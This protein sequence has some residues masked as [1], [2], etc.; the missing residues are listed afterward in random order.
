[1]GD[2]LKEITADADATSKALTEAASS[3]ERLSRLGSQTTKEVGGITNAFGDLE[4]S[5]LRLTSALKGGVTA[6][7]SILSATPA[8]GPLFEGLGKNIGFSVDVLDTFIGV[9]SDALELAFNLFD[10]PSRDVRSFADG[11][12]DLNKRFGGTIEQAFVFA[13]V[14]KAETMSPFARALHLT[15]DEMIAFANA[16]GRTNITLEQQGKIVDTGIGRTNLLAATMALA[17]ASSLTVTEGAGLLN[18]ALNKQGKSAQDALEIMG[19]FT[20]VARETGLSID[21]VSS[22]LNSAVGNFT[23]LGISADFGVPLLQGFAR[24]MMDMGLGIENATDLTT[25]LSSALA[26][27]TTDYANAYI[28]FQRGG[29]EMG[30]SGGGGALG[31]SIGLQAEVLKADRTGDQSSL[32]TQLAKGMRDTLASFT[33]GNIVTVEQADKSPELQTQFYTQQQLLQNQFGIKDAASANRT[34]ELLAQIDDATR[35]GD[36]DAKASLEKQLTHEKEGR[37]LTLDEFEKANRHLAAHSNLLA[38]IA[39]PTLMKQRGGAELLRESFVDPSI[40]RAAK[41]AEDGVAAYDRQLTKVLALAGAGADKFGMT[42]PGTDPKTSPA[43]AGAKS[44]RAGTASLS[45]N[46][47]IVVLAAETAAT[48]ASI[49]AI[50]EAGFVNKDDFVA[51]LAAAMTQSL[52]D[53]L[54]IKVSLTEDAKQQVAV[55]A[56]LQKQIQ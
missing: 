48:A 19:L 20:G 47:D 17:S 14:M 43:A 29:L 28:M 54:S 26:S 38:V 25:G 2:K 3:I 34:L 39:R 12:F 7:T 23:K 22:N 27:L 1:M 44:P 8:L 50:N 31:A 49:A 16:T 24:V 18:T 33:G 35:A 51:A 52:N 55:V 56:S 42:D 45:A 11:V 9:A 53:N 37:D 15:R 46:T 40:D 5:A 21:D 6:V 4:T 36:L 30:G 13:D 32:A 10:A 41:Y